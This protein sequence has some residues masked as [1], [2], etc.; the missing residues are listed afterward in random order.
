MG[1]TEQILTDHAARKDHD[2]VT[3]FTVA[4]LERLGIH[5][6]LFTIMQTVQHTLRMRKA[7]Q[8]VESHGCTDRWSLEDA[9]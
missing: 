1:I 8:V 5:D 3:W 6:Q 7:R 2:G 4:D 9:H